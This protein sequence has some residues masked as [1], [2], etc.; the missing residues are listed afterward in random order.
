MI[1]VILLA[2]ASLVA[3]QGT[4]FPAES[5][6]NDQKAG[7]V[8]IYNFYSSNAATPEIENTRISITNTS[9]TTSVAV[10]LFFVDGSSCSV[11][12]S[13]LCLTRN[14][15]TS[16]LASTIDPGTRGYLVA[17]AVDKYTGCPINFNFLI[18]DEYIKLASGHEANLGAEAFAALYGSTGSVLPGCNEYSM[19]ATIALDGKSYNLAA[20]ELAWDS[21]QSLAEG[22]SS[23]LIINRTGGD[24]RSSVG[25][26]GPVFGLLFDDMERSFSFTF[27][28][29]CQIQQ[30][31]SNAFP[32]TAPP[33]MTVIP[34]GHTGWM[35]FSS[36]NNFGLLGAGLNF[37]PDIATK[38]SAFIGGHNLHKLSFTADSYIIPV[39]PPK[40]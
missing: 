11:A 40:C 9:T 28:G 29:G 30:V 13:Y 24:L 19:S 14:Q 35:K 27:S 20:R 36:T 34:Y 39:F 17:V 22:N 12:D 2:P 10:H 5:R 4:P 21:I 37:N 38:P 32:H 7:S 8:L 26:I 1:T 16:F 3:A 25:S 6:V 31:L 33:F 15:T 18:G 23:L